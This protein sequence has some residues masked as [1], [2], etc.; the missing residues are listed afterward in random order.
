V[1]V[2]SSGKSSELFVV[3]VDPD[4]LPLGP[5]EPPG[6]LPLVPEPFLCPSPPPEP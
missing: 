5:L 2:V 4:P 3:V 1:V 6:V